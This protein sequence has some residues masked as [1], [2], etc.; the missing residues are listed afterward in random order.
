[1]ATEINKIP[2]R[3]PNNKPEQMLLGFIVDEASR[4]QYGK[5]VIEVTVRNG[6]LAS[7][8]STEIKRTAILE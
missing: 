2:L 7:I 1:M 3:T 5:I 8:Q 6:K 4:V